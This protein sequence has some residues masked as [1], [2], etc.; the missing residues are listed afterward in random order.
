[1]RVRFIEAPKA[2]DYRVGDVVDFDGPIPET[3]ARKFINRG[4]AV[5][6]KSDEVSAPV[7]EQRPAATAVHRGFGKW[8]VVDQHD[9]VLATGLDKAEAAAKADEINS[10]APESE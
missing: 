6:V 8:E 1:M 10:P 5:E 4:W 3:Y 9:Q 7:V 2:R